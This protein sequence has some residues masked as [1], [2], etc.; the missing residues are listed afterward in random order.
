MKKT[1]ISFCAALILIACNSEG[2]KT[3]DMQTAASLSDSKAKTDDWVPVDSV[4]AM[5]TMME[6]GTP[7]QPH[8]MLAKADG[9]WVG[10]TTM[11][12]SPGSPPMKM[13]TL[14]VNKM[15]LG[16]RYQHTSFKG[17]FMGEPFEGTSTTGYD[18]AKKMFTSTWVDNMSTGTMYMEGPWDEKT[19]SITF[20]G[21]MLCPANGKECE[22]KQVMKMIDDNTQVVDMYGPDMKTGKQYKSMEIKYTRKG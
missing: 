14:S 1:T 19:K 6:A 3:S 4:T 18:N 17:D 2:P 10:E 22:M 16:G 5:R 9:E 20:T 11:W 15:I 7:G 21:T 13:T 12:M 8:A